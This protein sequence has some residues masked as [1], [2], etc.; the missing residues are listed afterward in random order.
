MPINDGSLRAGFLKQVA[1]RPDAPALVVRN[2]VLT[3]GE[4]DETA[5]RWAGAVVGRIG[6]PAARVGIY[7]SRSEVSY[8][9][10]LAALYS[11]AAFVPLNPRFPAE[12]T[13]AMIARADLDAIFVDRLASTQLPAVL[14]GLEKAPPIW[15]PETTSAAELTAARPL[16]GELPPLSPDHVAYLL[17]TSGTTGVPKGVP[18]LQSNARAFISWAVDRYQIQPEDRFS[19]TFDQT[20]DLSVFDMFVAWECGAS[21][22]A[23]SHI[24]LLAPS[25]FINRNALTVWFSVPISS[26]ADAEEKSAWAGHAANTALE[27]VLRGAVAPGERRGMAGGGAEFHGREPLRTD[28]VDDCLHG[29]PL[30]SVGFSTSVRKRYGADR[31]AVSGPDSSPAG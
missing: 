7:G 23:M 21:V 14:D 29:A 4:L 19:Q 5:R 8:I 17:F 11:G 15:L 16:D 28:G 24:D 3:Y 9:G 30:G 1:L 27:P 13:R 25:K 18:I 2:R 12:R 20:F 6:G 31:E 26:G 10:A 22:Y